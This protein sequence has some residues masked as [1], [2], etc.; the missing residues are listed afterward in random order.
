MTC[1][2][3]V[4]ASLLSGSRIRAA[5]RASTNS[6]ALEEREASRLAKPSRRIV[7]ST[8]ST[9]PWCREAIT[10]KASAA[11]TSWWPLRYKRSSSI[12]S[13]GNLDRFARVRVLTLPSWR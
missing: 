4:V 1:Q 3:R 13:G 6:R 9:C 11:G 10:S 5:T 7:S 12:A 8:A 2:L